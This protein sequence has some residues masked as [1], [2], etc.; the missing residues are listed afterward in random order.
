MR[1]ASA[2]V[3]ISI[4]LP[5]LLAA[6]P[7]EDA[8][9]WKAETF[10][11]LA[12]RGIGPAVASGRISDL[13]LHPEDPATWYVAVASGGVWKTENYG[14]TWTPV[15]DGEGSYSIGCVS[16]DPER[17]LTVWVGTGE[18]N[19]QRSVGY[20]DGVYKSLDGGKNWTNVGLKDSAHVGKILID[21]RDG[22]VVY[23]AAMGPLWSPGGDRGLYKTADGGKSWTKVLDISENTGVSDVVFDPRNP[24]TLLAVAYQRRRH[25]WTLVNGGPESALYKSM[26]AGK[27]WRKIEKGLPD[28]EIGRIGIAVAPSRP[29]TVYA[30]VE[31][32]GKAGGVFRS[33]DGGET[34]EK[35]SDYNSQSA[36]YYQELFVD[37]K[38]PER[39]YSMD[40]WMHVTEDGG[41]T[42]KKVGEKSKHVDN[43]A[44]WIDPEDTDHLLAGCD[45]GLYETWDRGA[46]WKYFENLPIMQFYRVAVDNDSPFYNVYGG[47]QDNNTIGGP[48]RTSNAHGIRNQ[49]WFITQGGDGFE[50]AIDPT[51]PNIVY[52]Q[53]QHAGLVRFDRRTGEGIDI[54]PQA[55]PGEDPLRWNWDSPLIISPHSPTRLYFAAQRIFRSDD[56]GDS[57][58][59]I[60]PDLTAGIDRNRLP[61]MGRIQSVDAPAKNA[62][63]SFYGNIVSLTESPRVLG[64]L[65]AGTD[66]G[67]VQVTED[68]GANWRKIATFPGIPKYAYV[69]DLEASRHDDG[70][71]YASFDLHKM[72]DPKPYVLRST[73]RGRSWTSI[74]GDLPERGTVYTLAEDAIRKDL[75]FAGT[76]FGVFFTRDGGK[77][78]VRLS[79]GIPTIAI[80][81]IALQDRESDL[82]LASF[83]RGFYI[84]DDYSPLRLVT[85]ETLAAEATLFPVK[86]A[87]MYV[88]ATPIGWGEKGSMGD[89]YYTA[90]NPPF[91]AVFTAH[92][93][94]GYPTK[95]DLRR[96]EERKAAKDGKDVPYPP[97]DALRA[98]DREETPA[99]LFVVKD[100]E[101][102][103]VRRIPGGTKPGFQRASWDLRYPA[104]NPTRLDTGE[105]DPWDFAP[106]GPMVAPGIFTVELV[107]RI[108]GKESVLG[109]PEQFEAI[110]LGTASL[111]APDREK[112]LAFARKTARL[113]RAILGSGKALDEAKTRLA[114]LQKALDDTPGADPALRA[115]AGELRARLLDLDVEL[116]GDET[117]AR[118][119]EPTPPSITGRI[120]QVVTGHW[121]TTSAPTGTHLGEYDRA[122]EA[123][124]RWLPRFTSLVETDLG[125]LEEDAER[126]GSPWTPGR[127]PRWTR[128]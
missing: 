22:D 100:S 56:R 84:L 48:S 82:V 26:D 85:D 24:D 7:A 66:D 64:L 117:L 98:E 70:T 53:Y 8:S 122:A 47:T 15:F 74:A 41:K 17:P 111:P 87:S 119:N 112:V 31:A 35:R 71:V 36:Q 10:A 20:G 21:P 93:K 78:W 25:V 107:K 118:R 123:F 77:R 95:R 120:Q 30:L 94:E 76:E 126:T 39:V 4:L 62:S 55:A 81:D 63:T 67:L 19:S 109:K 44:L 125:R 50:P 99:L 12:F 42:W 75:L 114:H 73:D 40:T 96:K 23:V 51:D 37:P 127:V 106:V 91:G 11:G 80:R 79:G 29:D 69:S 9:P 121:T 32:S 49:D 27:S 104:S 43:H 101:G 113:Q 116:N 1:R 38:D 90:P 110:P 13:A 14:T 102:E 97:W 28:E 92:L 105:R 103:I 72:G 115:R 68:G 2:L 54:Q 59:A 6:K 52:S 5:L 45:G 18:N 34:W 65:Y 89:A 60:S 86:R 33:L 128:E 83:G 3:V 57:W 108:D 58:K 61:V 88:P 46:T 124:S 16:L